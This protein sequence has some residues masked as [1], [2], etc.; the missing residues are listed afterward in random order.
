MKYF[1][2]KKKISLN[3]AVM[4]TASFFVIATT[5][6]FNGLLLFARNDEKDIVTARLNFGK[7]MNFLASKSKKILS[8]ESI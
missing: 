4:G 8:E 3:L 6:I 5:K 7:T 1:P 2:S